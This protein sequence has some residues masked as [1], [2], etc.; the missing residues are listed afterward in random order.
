MIGQGDNLAADNGTAIDDGI[1]EHAQVVHDFIDG[2]S[3]SSP[4]REM[5][6][7]S[8]NSLVATHCNLN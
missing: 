8:H 4:F 2:L 6:G 3:R 7:K 1:A 5:T